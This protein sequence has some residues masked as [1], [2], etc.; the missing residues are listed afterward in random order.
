[1][2]VFDCGD[3]REFLKKYLASRKSGVGPRSLARKAGFKSSGHV[4]MLINGQRRLTL[5]SADLIAKSIGL[6]GRRRSLFLAF[7]RL[8]MAKSENEKNRIQEEILRLKS[9]QPE[10]QLNAKQF[11]VLAIWYYPVLYTLL[12]IPAADQEPAFLARRLGRGV[13]AAMVEQALADLDTLGL[14]TRHESGR[15]APTNAALT[16]PENVRDLA[17]NKYHRNSLKLAEEALDLPP[18]EREFNGLTVTIPTALLPQVKEKMRRL[19]SELNEMLAQANDSAEVYQIN[20][21]L[22]PVTKSLERNES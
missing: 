16:T 10:F 19:R 7:A 8:D 18:A 4:T 17:V 9:Y 3:H 13:T 21:Q 22:F 15:W 2:E 5:R 12:H 6:K 1:M 14:I 11:S 20:L